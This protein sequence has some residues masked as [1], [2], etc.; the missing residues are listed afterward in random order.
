MDLVG[1]TYKA[2]DSFPKS[3][4]FGLSNQM[5]RASV[6]IPSNIAEGAGRNSN[7]DFIRFLS[8]AL[9]SCFE[10]ETQ[11][12]LAINLGFGIQEDLVA[13]IEKCHEVQNRTV[14]F[15]SFLRSHQ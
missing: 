6:S 4:V 7:P 13:I 11:S 5:N 1:M 8:I 10:L 12:Q 2:T 15:Q 9:G 3:E 14:K